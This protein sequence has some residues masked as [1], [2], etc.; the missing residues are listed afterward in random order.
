MFSL[1]YRIPRFT[2]GGEWK[3]ESITVSDRRPNERTYTFEQLGAAGVQNTF[4]GNTID[5]LEHPPTC[6]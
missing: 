6:M 5:T 1:Q 2:E 3:V 4:T